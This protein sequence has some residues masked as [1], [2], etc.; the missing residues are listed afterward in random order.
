MPEYEESF[1]R[2]FNSYH[3]FRQESLFLT[4][5]YRIAIN[6]SN[7]YLKQ[8][9]KLPSQALAMKGQWFHE[10]F[11]MEPLS[12]LGIIDMVGQNAPLMLPLLMVYVFCFPF[13]WYWWD[14]QRAK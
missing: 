8:R 3:T 4:W 10:F 13:Q 5:I 1:I 11:H 12:F 6:V 2:A 9:K 7:D 14:S